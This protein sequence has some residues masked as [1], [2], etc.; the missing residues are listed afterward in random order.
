MAGYELATAYVNLVVETNDVGRQIGGMFKDADK[1]AAVSGKSAG[2]A[3]TRAVE[4]AATPQLDFKREADKAAAQVVTAAKQVAKAREGEEAAA[5]KVQ[6]AEAKLDELRASGK[7]K[8]SQLLT[9]EDALARAKQSSALASGKTEVAIKA[10]TAAKAKAVAA[11]DQLEASQR[12]VAQAADKAGDEF[13]TLKD[14]MQAALKGNFK[15]AFKSIPKDADTAADRVEDRFDKAGK[16]SGDGFSQGMKGALLGVAAYISV[17]AIAGAFKNVMDETG[18]LQQS[19]GAIDSVFKQSSQTML[20]WSEDAS[21]TV[22]LSQNEFNELGTLIGAQLKNAGTAMDDL[23]P[24]TNDLIGLGADLSS[25]FGGTTREAVE[26]VSSALK[27][28]RDPIERYGVSLRQ[29]GIDAKAA[30]LGFK[31]VDGAFDTQAQTAATV[32]LIM[33][34]TADAQGNFARESDTLAHK[35]QVAAAQWNN[36]K[37]VLGDMFLP[38]LTNVMGYVVDKGIP[39][40]EAFAGG[41]RDAFG[42]VRDNIVWLSI[43]AGSLAVLGISAWVATGGLSAMGLAIQGVF[44]AI[45]TGI[46]SIPVIGWIIAGIGLLVAALVWFFTKTELGKQIW[47]NTWNAI[48]VAAAA[49]FSWFQT[50]VVPAWNAVMQAIGTALSWVWNTILKPVFAALV[51]FWQTVISPA[52]TWLG[53]LFMTIFGAIGTFI[54][55]VWNSVLKPVFAALVIVWQTVIAPALAWLGNLFKTIFMAIG[56][57]ISWVWNSVLKP[58][59]DALVWVWKSVIAPV[60]TWLWGVFS[61]IFSLIGAMIVYWWNNVVKPK[62]DALVSF[63]KTVI[64]PALSWLWNSVFKPIFT[65][66]GEKIAAWW[67]GVKI[68]FQAVKDFLANTLGPAFTWF[69]DHIITPVWNGIKNTISWVWENGIQPVFRA[70]GNFIKDK[71]APAFKNGVKAIGKAW[72]G[73]KETAKKPI[74]F[75]VNTVIN[76]GIVGTFNKIA[77]HFPGAKEMP[78]LKLPKGFRT[79]GKV[80]GE[81][82]ETSDSIPA[83]LSKNEHVWTAKEVRAAG[84]HGAMYQWRR[85][86]LQ[87]NTPPGFAKGGTLSDAARWLQKK[88]VRISEFGA[89]GQRVG[90]HAPGSLHY[91]NRAFDANAG[92]GGQNATEMR[93]F[94]NLVP[95][96][97]E[98]FPGLRTLWRVAGH[99]NHL[100]VDTGKGGA[101]GSGGPGDQS[102]GAGLLDGF[103]SPFTDLKDKLSGQFS[104]FGKFGELAKGMGRKAIETPIEWIK[105]NV[106]KVGDFVSETWDNITQTAAQAAVRTRAT[107]YGWGGG[108][109]WN[110]LKTLV[111]KESG[112]RVDAAN[113]NSSARGLFQKMTSL[114]GPVEKTAFGQAGWGL[115]YIKNTYGTPVK[116]L[117]KWRSRSPHWYAQ[118]GAV[119]PQ[120]FDNGGQVHKGVQL[121]EHRSTRPDQVLTAPQWSDM[122]SLAES[123]RDG[124][125]M[126]RVALSEE[127][128]A[129]LRE[130]GNIKVMLDRRELAS[131]VR[132]SQS[133]N[134]RMGA[135]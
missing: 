114:H 30:E 108:A 48:K 17:E 120:L 14:R 93:I 23:A 77:S 110:A 101:V 135:R 116:A 91:S 131:A 2:A 12:D 127:D 128:R 134:K 119:Q 15:G 104:K 81:G 3:F 80:W 71:V 94:D 75:V 66:I 96:L 57:F 51:I 82:T 32:A 113:P 129:L 5:R 103:L 43:A 109:Q 45:A 85:A 56:T 46:K 24:K 95:Q 123:V 50:Y 124:Q 63:W 55:W 49:V 21:H 10:E 98:L 84:G 106:A 88:N 44:L 20:R 61:A 90:R 16:E 97:H 68:V 7:A 102:G 62:F 111:G 74:R 67:L 53:G 9:A 58:V 47:E 92:P 29:A 112:W 27:G 133:R 39:A 73:I 132:D 115:K 35:Q 41:V 59:F 37:T 76:E 72:D 69:R 52:L 65:W 126:S 34:Q 117:A 121:I 28:E 54:S 11:N 36:F 6:I 105:S 89:W 19:V 33:E 18:N 122:H 1:V 42:W 100:H 118:G 79:G 130:L 107:G 83:R 40:L 4:A 87:G 60:L 26:A 86:V 38:A 8:A 22:G 99:F 13:V 70:L 25:M 31:K 64:A 125:A 78:P